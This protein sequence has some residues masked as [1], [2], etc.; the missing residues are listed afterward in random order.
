MWRF[1]AMVYASPLNLLEYKVPLI[2][3]KNKTKKTAGRVSPDL[4]LL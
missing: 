3:L 1:F 2:T 4:P